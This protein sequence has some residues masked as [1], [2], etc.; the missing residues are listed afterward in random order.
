MTE[1]TYQ[2]PS[3]FELALTAIFAALTVVFGQI[4]LTPF[5]GGPSVLTLAII[6]PPLVG[7]ILGLELGSICILIAVLFLFMVNPATAYA[8]LFT[9]FPFLAGT[10]SAGTIRKSFIYKLL[11]AVIL[12]IGIL[13]YL[14][15]YSVFPYWIV[16][17]VLALVFILAIAVSGKKLDFEGII[18]EKEGKLDIFGSF[19]NSPLLLLSC[20]ISTMA[21]QAVMLLLAVYVLQLPLVVFQLALPLMLMER[22]IATIVSA[23]GIILVINIMNKLGHKVY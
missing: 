6:M 23:L 9:V 13:G 17:H 2:K 21:D 18:I 16:P 15:V 5:I 12:F 3:S 22:T 8:G 1:I 4:P 11:A 19:K 7:L 20:F 10:V 14:Y